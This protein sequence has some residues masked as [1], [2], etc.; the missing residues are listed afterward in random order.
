MTLA[1]ERNCTVKKY[2][3]VDGSSTALY[4]KAIRG[5]T[6]GLFEKQEPLAQGTNK[7]YLGTYYRIN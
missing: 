5:R 3:I 6:G 2:T 4:P 1:D 7:Q